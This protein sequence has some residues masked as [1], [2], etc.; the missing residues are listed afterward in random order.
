MKIKDIENVV[1][2]LKLAKIGLIEQEDKDERELKDLKGVQFSL[3][4]DLT[5]VLPIKSLGL[6]NLYPKIVKQ[7]FLYFSLCIWF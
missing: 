6:D 3:P 4:I 5:T 1:K 2:L 7:F